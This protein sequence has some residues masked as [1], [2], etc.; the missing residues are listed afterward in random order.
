MIA[1]RKSLARRARRLTDRVQ[2]A[3]RELRSPAPPKPAPS[4]PAPK[5]PAK[6]SRAA[7]NGRPPREA[8][9]RA[10]ARGGRLDQALAWQVRQLLAAE[11]PDEAW[12]LAESLRGQP[13]TAAVGQAAAG[14]VA[15]RTG[16]PELAREHLRDVP[17]ELWTRVAAPAYLRAGLAVEPEATLREIRELLADEPADVP[18]RSWFDVLSAVFGYGDD[19]LARD[20]FAVL[21]RRLA[22]DPG[23]WR[24]GRR[25]ADWMRP[26]MSDGASPTAPPPPEGRRAFAIVDY[27]HPGAD[28][29]SANIGDHVQSIAS[30]G[31]LVRHRGV[32]F[33]GDAE[34]VALLDDLAARTRPERRLDDVE[35]D[36]EVLTVHRDASMYEAIPEDTWV[37]CF[38]WYMHAIFGTRHGFPLHRNLRPVFISFH[39]NKRDLLTPAAVEYLKRYGPVGC[40]DWTTVYLLLSLGVPAFFSGCLTTTIDTVFPDVGEKP[41]AGA[42]V[43]YVDVEP[44]EDGTLYKHSSAEV[45]RRSFVA[46]MRTA[47]GLLDTYRTRHRKVVTSRLHCYLPVRSLGVNVD[48]RPANRADIRF[49]GLAGLGNREFRA[50]RDGINAKLER[51]MGAIL[52]GRSEEEVYGLWRELTAADVAAAEERRTA[53]ARL[54]AVEVEVA[55]HARRSPETAADT[56]HVAAMINRHG[57]RSLSALVDS[58]LEHA[59]RP[60]HLWVLALPGTGDAAS[61]ELAARFP[62]LPFTQVPLRGLGAELATP[63]G[64]RVR[65]RDVMRLLLGELLPDVD[66]LVL[67]PTPSVVEGDIAELA[68][69]DLG[70]HALAAPTR[71]GTAVSGFGVIHAAALRL[72][73]LPEAAAELRRTAHAR[74]RFDFDAFTHELLVLDL[75]RLRRD[76]LGD[77][78]LRLVAGLRAQRPRGPALPDRAGPGGDPAAVGGRADLDAGARSEARALGRPG[79]AVAGAAH[80]RARPLAAPCPR[81]SRAAAACSAAWPSPPTTPP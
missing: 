40:R 65:P 72:G 11:E 27:G 64:E 28:R 18:A 59:S 31:H 24:E 9:V 16:Y 62:S 49:D 36:L 14:I 8:L 39:C 66:R 67:L 20:V 74:H 53:E 70:G 80:A 58:L 32:R 23:D 73:A 17:R 61:D 71:P 15:Y 75:E 30:L 41:P 26:W 78:A 22:A 77:Q 50:M 1:R 68:G 12:A 33:H 13:E 44:Q 81:L 57:V 42:P 76:R 54:P 55:E 5:P 45:R 38:G 6:R 10:L 43:A 2:R 25:H 21:E 60:V 56:V 46:N 63:A 29:A 51:I 37:L 79:E 52:A 48:F 3:T 47:L 4:K 19:A 34:L 35:T 7:D 69:L